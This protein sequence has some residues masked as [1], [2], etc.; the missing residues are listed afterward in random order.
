MRARIRPTS[1]SHT[2]A[3]AGLASH[4]AA[5]TPPAHPRKVRLLEPRSSIMRNLPLTSLGSVLTYVNAKQLKPPLGNGER[6][7][8]VGRAVIRCV[9]EGSA[10][11]QRTSTQRARDPGGRGRSG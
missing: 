8:A 1:S 9:L 5:A 4:P 6:W 11:G 7:A 10:T 2:E 3:S